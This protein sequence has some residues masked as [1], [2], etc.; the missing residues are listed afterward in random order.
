M[1]SPWRQTEFFVSWTRPLL[2]FVVSLGV[3]LSLAWFMYFLTHSS[4]MR[5]SDSDRVQMLDF[6]RLKRD[7]VADRKE[8]KP[9]R[10]EVN[11]VPDAP[12]AADQRSN[13]ANTLTVSAPMAMDAGLDVGR[14]MGLGTGDGEYLP[15]VKVAPIYPRRAIDRGIVGTCMVTYTV[16]TAGTVKDVSV[17]EGECEHQVFERPSVDAAYRFKYKPRVI[18]GEPVEVLGILNRFFY[19]QEEARGG[20]R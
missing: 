17:V 16:T 1:T 15:I 4:E 20:D 12:P 14:G 3:A 9:E 6:V 13:A 19:E 8:R 7:E 10:P 11:E 5:L 2:G 18:N